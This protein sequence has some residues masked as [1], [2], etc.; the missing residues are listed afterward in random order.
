MNR[1]INLLI[2]ATLLVGSALLS[3]TAQAAATCTVQ[4]KI[5]IRPMDNYY[6][7]TGP[8]PSQSCSGWLET[9]LDTA[10]NP[11]QYMRIVITN[12]AGQNTYARTWTDANGDYS[13]T[14]TVSGWNGCT[15]RLVDIRLQ[16]MRVHEDDADMSS[17]ER[18]R[19]HIVEPSTN[20]TW[21]R[22]HWNDE[23]LDGTT[24]TRN[25][26]FTRSRFTGGHRR[27]AN[28]YYTVNSAL[29]EIVTWTSNLSSEFSDTNTSNILAVK[30]DGNPWSQCSG[31]GSLGC[32][33]QANWD[34]EL[35][36]SLYPNGGFTRHELGHMVHFALHDRD[37]CW[38]S[39][40]V[41]C[42]SDNYDS[43]G[44]REAVSCEWGYH[45]MVEGFPSFVAVRSLTTNDTNAWYCICHDTTNQDVCSE[46]AVG[47]L[48]NDR[49]DDCVGFAA[50][51]WGFRGVGDD[52]ATTTDHC[53]RVEENEGC[54]CVDTSPNDGICDNY[55]ELGW[56]NTQ[57]VVRFFWDVVDTNNEGGNDNTDLS[58]NGTNGLA[59]TIED[60][61]CSGVY[62]GIDGTCNEPNRGTGSSCS[63]SATNGSAIFPMTATRDSYNVWDM[64]AAIAGNQTDEREINCVDGATD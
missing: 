14:F 43:S 4:G 12:S 37:Q 57:Q 23:P 33:S 60:M 58:M 61:S 63:P 52:F 56:R 47:T 18:R 28:V 64:A 5:Q 48:D 13:A 49:I 59:D 15:G 26:T 7:D 31:T 45:A 30:Y 24:T 27:V 34:I 35:D 40:C 8:S 53:V 20:A 10:T 16:F 11:M 1:A 22:N 9:N 41:S 50:N 54:N 38:G 39:G 46:T 19:F 17:G 55:D 36:E 32:A 25:Y 21:E 2:S 51:T 42:K 62:Y 3:A 6:C 29:S 44:G